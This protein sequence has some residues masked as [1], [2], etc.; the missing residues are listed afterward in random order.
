MSG[1]IVNIAFRL[2]EEPMIYS[3]VISL[4]KS[5]YATMTEDDI[6]EEKQRR[7]QAWLALV[8]PPEVIG[9]VNNG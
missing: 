1:E 5:L 7:Y 9:D 4:P 2:G 6:E 8:N 3:D